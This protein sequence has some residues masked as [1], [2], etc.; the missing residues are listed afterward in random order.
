MDHLFIFSRDPEKNSTTY[1]F[2]KL[3]PYS[4]ES[5]GYTVVYRYIYYCI[6]RYI[7]SSIYT[8]MDYNHI[9]MF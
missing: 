7:Y 5:F 4:A 2:E 6:Y 3:R 8:Y 9:K 1:I